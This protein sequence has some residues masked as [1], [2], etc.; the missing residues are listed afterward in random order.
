MNYYEELG[1]S[2]T[3]SE[4]EI[5]KAYHRMVRLLH[6]DQQLDPELKALAETQMMRM[7]GIMKILLNSVKR[8]EYEECLRDSALREE[9]PPAVRR[10]QVWVWQSE[11]WPSQTDAAPV[12]AGKTRVRLRQFGIWAVSV[13][14][15][16]ATLGSLSYSLVKGTTRSSATGTLD[17]EFVVPHFVL[18][19]S[20]RSVSEFRFPAAQFN[21]LPQQIAARELNSAEPRLVRAVSPDYPAEAREGRVEGVVHFI[22][23]VAKDG[24]V[25]ALELTVGPDV[26]R[27]AAREAVLQWQYKPALLNGAPVESRVEADVLFRLP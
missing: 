20:A 22:A 23:T 2:Q 9:A 6:P 25:E 21:P 18:P 19:T 24:K 13:L 7:N 17:H 16:S 5:R 10:A 1:I 26:L 8:R 14:L 3:A 4:P 27:A 12:E 15:L 11:P